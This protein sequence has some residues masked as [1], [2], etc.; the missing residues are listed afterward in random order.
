M[1]PGQ[2]ALE[3][4]YAW[5]CTMRGILYSAEFGLGS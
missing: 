1:R 3:L 2:Q 4:E 5:F